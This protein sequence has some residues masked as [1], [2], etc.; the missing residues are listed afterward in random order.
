VDEPLTNHLYKEPKKAERVSTKPRFIEVYSKYVN[1]NGL[2]PKKIY[3]IA[4]PT[5]A[6]S[7]KQIKT[8]AN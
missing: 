5:K 2:E 1:K 6:V 8:E 3:K 7:D 4:D